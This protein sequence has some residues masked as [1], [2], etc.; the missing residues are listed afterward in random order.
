MTFYVTSP[1][2]DVLSV[3]INFLLAKNHRKNILKRTI[4]E[5]MQATNINMPSAI[6]K[7]RI[8]NEH[9]LKTPATWIRIPAGTF[10]RFDFKSLLCVGIRLETSTEFATRVPDTH[11]LTGTRVLV[12]VNLVSD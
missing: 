6:I 10:K 3:I 7:S 5:G 9:F 4:C 1:N 2:F 8:K 12:T 11:Y